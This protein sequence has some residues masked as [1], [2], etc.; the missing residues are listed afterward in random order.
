MHK[1]KLSTWL[2]KGTYPRLYLPIL[3]IIALVSGIRYHV[4]LSAEKQEA[5]ARAA[6]ELQRIGLIVLPLL[7]QAA[8]PDAQSVEHLLQASASH[9][10]P[11]LKALHWQGY[12]KRRP[13]G[14]FVSSSWSHPRKNLC[15][16]WKMGTLAS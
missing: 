11:P 7:A 2:L 9:L 4:L 8:E 6:I 3:L 13:T 15:I 14:S 10:Q 5:N 16:P 1:A 12:S